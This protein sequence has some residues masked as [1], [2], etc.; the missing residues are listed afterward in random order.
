MYTDDAPDVTVRLS[1]TLSQE[2]MRAALRR[3]KIPTEE[4]SFEITPD[5]DI[6]GRVTALEIPIEPGNW[7]MELIV[8]RRWRVSL[9]HV[10]PDPAFC[11]EE[12]SSPF[13][14]WR[15]PRVETI[16]GEADPIDSF[17]AD[18]EALVE[19]EERHQAGW[20]EGCV[21]LQRRVARLLP[22]W[23][24][25]MLKFLDQCEKHYQE[26]TIGGYGFA[27]D[28]SRRAD[29]PALVAFRE[30]YTSF[31]LAD[32][33]AAQRADELFSCTAA[34]MDVLYRWQRRD[35]A[36]AR[37]RSLVKSAEAWTL[38]H[39]SVRLRRALDLG[40]LDQSLGVYR[41]ERLALEHPGWRWVDK[42]DLASFNDILNPSEVEL[43]VLA[44]AREWTPFAK[45]RWSGRP[46]NPED[47]GPVVVAPFLDRQILTRARRQPAAHTYEEEP[48]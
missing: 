8:N 32:P 41:D 34:A 18:A 23:S 35:D 36:D 45:L 2:A 26:W 42:T 14:I 11:G 9:A 43:D 25:W 16:W 21:G 7:T 20:Q 24:D 15:Q 6:W 19:L 5:S 22:K 37:K 46:D 17:P 40:V 44:E 38:E 48:F 47:G 30:A 10:E 27:P 3:G 28:G 31:D 4:V 12:S 33:R 39:G 13:A 1:A 29:A